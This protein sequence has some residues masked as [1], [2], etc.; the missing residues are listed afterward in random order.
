[1]SDKERA[2]HSDVSV[3]AYDLDGELEVQCSC[4]ERLTTLAEGRTELS[5]LEIMALHT[6]HLVK[7]LS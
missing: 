2:K 3:Y 5:M 4:G 1:M 6:A 7:V